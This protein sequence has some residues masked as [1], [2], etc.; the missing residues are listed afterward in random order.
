MGA[1]LHHDRPQNAFAQ[2]HALVLLGM[3]GAG[4]GTQA[5]E[6]SAKF[7]VPEISTGAMLR[8]AV[9]RRTSLGLT[10]QEAMEAGKLVP[11]ELVCALVEERTTRPDCARGFILDGFPRN[12]EQ[13]SFLDQS[14]KTRNWGTVL[15]LYIR[16]DPHVLFRRVTGRLEC[17][18]C[19][20]IYNIYL[21]PPQ[22]AEICDKDGSRLIRRKDDSEDAF[23]RRL[24]EFECQTQ[25]VIERYRHQNVLCE[26]DGNRDPK[27]VTKEVFRLLR[28]L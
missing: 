18:T 28:E 2:Y 11:D 16:V 23:H 25:P 3:P 13:A 5:G 14:F 4:K 20:S 10:A 8:E 9:E 15:A 12:L 7:G 17:P 27:S 1:A 21:N 6:I 22:R 24:R 26:V 19:G